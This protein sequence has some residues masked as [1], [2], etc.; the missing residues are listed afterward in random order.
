M[1]GLT[2]SIRVV[3]F[4]EQVGLSARADA[5]RDKIPC[6]QLIRQDGEDGIE[7]EQLAPSHLLGESAGTEQGQRPVTH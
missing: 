6:G 1:P 7:L 2:G 3:A 5:R 4:P